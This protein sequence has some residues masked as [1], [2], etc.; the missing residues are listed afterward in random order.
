MEEEKRLGILHGTLIGIS[1]SRQ[2][3]GTLFGIDMV[4]LWTCVL[5]N[6]ELHKKQHIKALGCQ[7]SLHIWKI[8]LG[9]FS[10]GIRV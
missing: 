4:W 2:D 8:S 10:F 9:A 3:S 1:E 5:K 7:T 6:S